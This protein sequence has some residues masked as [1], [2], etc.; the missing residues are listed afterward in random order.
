MTDETNAYGVKIN[1][2]TFISMEAAKSIVDEARQDGWNLALEEAAEVCDE[3]EPMN[4]YGVKECA[5]AIRALK[6]N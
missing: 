5:T 1:G 2:V 6:T 3:R 4:L